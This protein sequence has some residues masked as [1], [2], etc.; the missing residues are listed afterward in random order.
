MTGEQVQLLRCKMVYGLIFLLGISLITAGLAVFP[1]YSRSLGLGLVVC[2]VVV[3]VASAVLAD[4]CAAHVYAARQCKPPEYEAVV[5]DDE[6]AARRLH[7]SRAAL[8]CPRDREL[9]N[10]AGHTLKTAAGRDGRG[11]GVGRGTPASH[12]LPMRCSTSSV[13]GALLVSLCV[14]GIF[15]IVL[16][17]VTVG[18]FMV[19][20]SFTVSLLFG[21]VWLGRTFYSGQPR[22]SSSCQQ[23]DATRLSTAQ[24]GDALMAIDIPPYPASQDK[25]APHSSDLL[26]LQS[27][28]GNDQAVRVTKLPPVQRESDDFTTVFL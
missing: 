23:M 1:T 17:D 22:R 15:C 20:T 14:V 5:P 16:L 24:G 21:I 25:G 2:G 6:E 9:R 18:L 7:S 28:P 26:R 11:E 27:V 10:R 13:V 19:G 12:A 3:F 4:A 8:R